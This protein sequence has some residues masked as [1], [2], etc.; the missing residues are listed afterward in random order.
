MGFVCV[1][2]SE[3][4]SEC[5]SAIIDI[6][7]G[8]CVCMFVP[9][10]I[11]QTTDHYRLLLPNCNIG[12]STKLLGEDMEKWPKN[13]FEFDDILPNDRNNFILSLKQI[14]NKLIV[15]PK[16]R[17]KW[18]VDV[19]FFLSLLSTIYKDI[20]L[21]ITFLG[22]SNYLSPPK[23]IFGDAISSFSFFK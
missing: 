22:A 6:D 2:G 20:R 17:K 21:Q 12:Q 10:K 13:Q 1:H 3:K 4:E 16:S 19:V 5:W 11:R 18:N 15:W 7:F 23:S 8:S 14:F 9:I